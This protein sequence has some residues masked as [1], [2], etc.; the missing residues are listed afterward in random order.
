MSYLPYFN[1]NIL[2]TGPYLN[3]KQGRKFVTTINQ[4]TGKRTQKTYAK[5][6]MEIHLNRELSSDETVDHIDRNKLNDV[7]SNYQILDR[8]NHTAIDAKRVD[9]VHLPCAW[10]KGDTVR[11]PRDLRS[12]SK[13]RAGPFCSSKCKGEYG[14]S[15]QNGGTKLP[16][17]PHIPSSFSF[18]KK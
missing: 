1:K 8:A 3:K 18:K 13:N 17:Q 12:R 4:T 11:K 6:L 7:I 5:Y 2:V 16:L 10:C 14:A 9:L 15:V